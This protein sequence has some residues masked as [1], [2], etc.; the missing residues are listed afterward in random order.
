M[1]NIPAKRIQYYQ[2]KQINTLPQLSKFSAH[3]RL[4]MQAIA[5]V[6]PFRSN[7][8]VVEELIDWDNVPD[9]PIYR[10]T[11]PHPEMLPEP[12]LNQV[13]ALLDRGADELELQSAVNQIRRQLNPNPA[14]QKKYN[15][16]MLFDEPVQGIQH[17]YKQT[18]LV[19][20][21]AG[22]TCHAYCTFCFRWPQF[23]KLDDAKFATRESG[24]FLDYLQ[25]HPEVTDVLFTGGDPMTMS[26]KVLAR[27]I[28]P[29]LDPKYDHIQTI[30]IGTKSISYW[31]YRYVT[32]KDSDEI[33]QLFERIVQRGKH[34]ALMAHYEHW[35]ELA[36]PV[37]E[38]AI[39]RIRATGAQIRTQAP[40]IRH[41]NDNADDWA[42]MWKMQ[43]KLGCV[44][45]YMFVERQTGAKQY[46]ELPLVRTWELYQAAIQQVSGLGRT[47]RGPVMSALPGKVMINGITEVAGEKVFVLTFLQARDPDW[48]N[49]PFFAKFDP[50]A[51]WLGDL[52][53]AFGAD[54][55]FYE[56]QLEEMLTR[57][58]LDREAA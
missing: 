35:Q 31:P 2:A 27:Y 22:Q 26:A 56:S 8:Y 5:A 46:F 37:A 51:T 30:R 11:F 50:T 28:E 48:C 7:N 47:A 40:V 3:E 45:Y 6:L 9:D 43:V 29:F 41:V 20:P 49:R 55:F 34:L 24:R 19:F 38:A 1:I 4:Q 12:A 10:L 36:T 32:D 23:V 58:V 16:P 25:H 17:K 33:L 21:T 13:V 15:V 18:V 39:A 44:P 52:K 42:K 53:P 14:G 57:T 54:K